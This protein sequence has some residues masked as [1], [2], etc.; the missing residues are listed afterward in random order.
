MPEPFARERVLAAQFARSC[1]LVPD[2]IE[3]LAKLLAAYRD[4]VRA[5]FETG[6]KSIAKRAR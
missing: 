1:C 3:E 4:E 5:A 2:Q 6:Q